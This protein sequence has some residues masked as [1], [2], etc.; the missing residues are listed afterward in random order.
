MYLVLVST[1]CLVK[2]QFRLTG[3]CVRAKDNPNVCYHGCENFSKVQTESPKD[4]KG[5]SRKQSLKPSLSAKI[6]LGRYDPRAARVRGKAMQSNVSLGW[7]Q[8]EEKVQADCSVISQG[9][10]LDSHNGTCCLWSK[11]GE[12]LISCSLSGCV[13]DPPGN[14]QRQEEAEPLRF[15]PESGT[16]G[17]SLGPSALS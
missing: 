4:A 5:L 2:Q 9:Q 3:E 14:C 12:V 13:P 15:S 17:R 6:L 1:D 11:K 10:L 7:K 16:G 8:L